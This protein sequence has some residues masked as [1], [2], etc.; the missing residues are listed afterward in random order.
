MADPGQDGRVGDLVAVQ[1]Q[2]RQHDAVAHRVQELV[3][4]PAGGQRPGLRLAVP[5][6]A[7]H[8]QG[9]I[10]EGGAVGMGQRVAKLPALV[11]RAG[12]LGRDVAGDAAG[13]RELGEQPLQA[14]LVLGDAWVDLAVGP[15]QIG[16]GD[17]PRT[18]V[19]G[20]GDEDHV[21]VAVADDPVQ[22][23]VD[24]VQARR[25]APMAQKPRLDVLVGQGLLQQRI[26]EEIDLSDRE[27]VGRP[28]VGVDQGALLV[29]Q[30]LGPGR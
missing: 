22:V 6:H 3:G 10:V 5:D 11:D 17:D 12:R 4:V 30:R 21:H 2:D 14:D 19:A 28:P 24:E 1:V 26:V 8:D 7:G 25:R 20:A 23:G 13:E 15:L 16:V 27:V 18:A 9:R 29:R